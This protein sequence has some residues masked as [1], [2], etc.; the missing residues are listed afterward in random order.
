MKWINYSDIKKEEQDREHKP[1]SAENLPGFRTAYEKACC[2][3]DIREYCYQ[4]LYQKL[5]RKYPDEDLCRAVMEKLV[6]CGAVDDRRYAEHYAEYLVRSKGYG[7]RRA[8]QEMW[9]KGLDRSL[10]REFLD[11]QRTVADE[12]LPRILVK[13]YERHL[14]DREDYRAREKAVAGMVRLGYDF[15]AVRNAIEDYFAEQEED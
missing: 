3:L 13:K 5:L 15:Q 2:Y 4:E 10:I 12:N 7:I 14:Q 11:E 9:H 1:E 8:E 6:N